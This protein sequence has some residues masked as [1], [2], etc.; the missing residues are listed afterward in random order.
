MTKNESVF[1]LLL[2]MYQ[3]PEHACPFVTARSGRKARSVLCIQENRPLISRQ[4]WGKMAVA[5]ISR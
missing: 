3:V 5:M 4:I 2:K 1:V